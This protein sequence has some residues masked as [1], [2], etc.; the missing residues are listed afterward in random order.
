MN[1]LYKQLEERLKELELVEQINTAERLE[2]A[3]LIEKK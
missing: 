1:E 2:I 3:T